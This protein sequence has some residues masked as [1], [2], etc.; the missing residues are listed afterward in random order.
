MAYDFT[1][2]NV[3]TCLIREG[4]SMVAEQS[5]RGGLSQQLAWQLSYGRGTPVGEG[6]RHFQRRGALLGRM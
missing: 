2:L 1:I 4:R 3:S 5:Y 6:N